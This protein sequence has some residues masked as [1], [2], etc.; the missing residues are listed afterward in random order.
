[1]P[2]PKPG[3]PS[4]VEIVPWSAASL[5]CQPDVVGHGLLSRFHAGCRCPWC[6]SVCRERECPCQVCTACRSV[7][8]Y[9]PHVLPPEVA[10]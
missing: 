7:S 10:L 4:S 1:M 2:A 5:A 8:P 6:T 3:K 9:V